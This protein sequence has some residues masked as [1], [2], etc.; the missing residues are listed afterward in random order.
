MPVP[1]FSRG[2]ID[3]LSIGIL[4]LLFAIQRYGTKFVGVVFAPVVTLWLVANF[5][6]GLYNIIVHH[7]AI[8]KAMGP[9]YLFMYLVRN[10]RAGWESLGSVLFCVT[11]ALPLPPLRAWHGEKL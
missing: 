5:A 8:L 9:N 1:S 4:V 10:G 7:P 6:V 2:A 3:G 11:G